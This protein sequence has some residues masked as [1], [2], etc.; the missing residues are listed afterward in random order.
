MGVK[1]PDTSLG[2]LISANQAAFS[3]RPWLFWFPGLFI[4]LIC[5]SINFVGDGLRDAFDP[6]QKKLSL[7]RVKESAP[8]EVPVPMS[9]AGVVPPRDADVPD[10]LAED[11][12]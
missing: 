8:V 12:R 2:L 10:D 7:R 6:Q 11:G 4:I 9:A 3:T 5:L 1:P